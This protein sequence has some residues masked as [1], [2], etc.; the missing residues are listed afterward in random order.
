MQTR[1]SAADGDD[2]CVC[3][4]IPTTAGETQPPN[5]TQGASPRGQGQHARGPPAP[6]LAYQRTTASGSSELPL[7]SCSTS[8]G[9]GRAVRRGPHHIARGR[10]VLPARCDAR[11]LDTSHRFAA[12]GLAGPLPPVAYAD[13]TSGKTA[14]AN[15][16]RTGRWPSAGVILHGQFSRSPEEWPADRLTRRG[17]PPR[18]CWTRIG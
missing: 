10:L 8:S 4:S 9:D 3:C 5:Y 15:S 1:R 12:T 6:R 2:A 11:S 7:S 16:D 18:P 13:F 14:G 17:S